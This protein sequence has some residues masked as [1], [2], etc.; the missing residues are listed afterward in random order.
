MPHNRKS[1][2]ERQTKVLWLLPLNW[3]EVQWSWIEVVATIRK[4][5][6]KSQIGTSLHRRQDVFFLFFFVVEKK[7][8]RVQNTNT[9][10]IDRQ[11]NAHR[12]CGEANY[13]SVFLN[14]APVLWYQPTGLLHWNWVTANSTSGFWSNPQKRT[15]SVQQQQQQQPA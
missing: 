5:A 4:E 6:E 1:A 2:M 10:I 9:G 8:G 12:T 7:R 3:I 11:Y 14:S 15:G 13:L